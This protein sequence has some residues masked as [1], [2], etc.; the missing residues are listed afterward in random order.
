MKRKKTCE[1]IVKAIEDHGWELTQI[2]INATKIAGM[3]SF[4]AACYCV[5]AARWI[6]EKESMNPGE[7]LP[8]IKDYMRCVASKD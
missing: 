5:L 4:Q 8:R 7:T 3:D 2:I 1:P 6:A